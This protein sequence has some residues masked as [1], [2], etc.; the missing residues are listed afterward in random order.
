M[1]IYKRVILWVLACLVLPTV[2]TNAQVNVD[3]LY[4]EARKTAFDKQDYPTALLLSKEILEKNPGNIDVLIFSGRLYS[5]SK[6][7][8]SARVYFERAMQLN[9][10]VEDVY[11]AYTD[12]EYW[13]K[14]YEKALE[15]VNAGLA[16][17]PSSK[18]L[19]LR[20]A[21]ILYDK[22]EF[23]AGL[24]VV[25]TM[26]KMDRGNSDARLLAERLRDNM[27]KNRIGVKYDMIG[28]TERDINDVKI[29]KDPWHYLSVDYTRQT[30]AGAFCARINYANR[31]GSDG[32]QYEVEAYPLISKRFYAYLNAGFSDKIGV[33]PKWKGGASLYAN[34]PA[35]FEA[36]FG[37]RYLDFTTNADTARRTL[38]YTA[39][40]GKYLKSFL[41]GA[42]TYLAPAATSVSESYSLMGR[43]YY[44]GVD[45]FIGL[46]VG[47]GISPDSRQTNVQLNSAEK[48][49]SYN[50]ELTA[51]H[52]VKRLNVLSVNVSLI[53]QEYSSGTKSNQWQMGIGYIRRL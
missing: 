52:A 12:V 1:D 41:V 53:S 21:R 26:L 9:A 17:Y 31:F 13:N 33:F 2:Y 29:P 6:N 34:L 25:D 32:F 30:K 7:A 11:F 35:A 36:E 10:R 20:K 45:D 19:L 27:S 3:S 47:A 23:K 16:F 49:L 8:D 40:V 48:I 4:I 37:I 22:R 50:G 46:S 39:Y 42:R 51:R 14:N 38:I 43:Y 24:K 18:E 5:W 15:I 28:F 44:G